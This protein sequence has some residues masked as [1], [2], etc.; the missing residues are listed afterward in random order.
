M[1]I[2]FFILLSYNNSF[3]QNK[4]LQSSD[5]VDFKNYFSQAG[6]FLLK[7]QSNDALQC[8]KKCL[9]LNS[10]S[11][12]TNFQIAKI[13]YYSG[14]YNAAELFAKN[15]VDLNSDNVFYIKFLADVYSKLGNYNLSILYS[16]KALDKAPTY[17][18]YN[19]L[20]ELYISTK[21]YNEAIEHLN[22]FENNFGFDVDIIIQKADLF[23]LSGDLNSA[24]KE[25]LRLIDFDS[26]NLS[27]YYLLFDFYSITNQLSKFQDVVNKMIQ[28]DSTNGLSYLAK[29]LMCRS[30]LQ[31]DCFYQNLVESF[32]SDDIKFSQKIFYIS[33]LIMDD[34]DLSI[35]QF[36]NLFS[37][38]DSQYHDS[39]SVHSNFADFYL[40][41]HNL[42][43]AIEQLKICLDIDKSDFKIW[44]K[45]FRIYT[46]NEDYSSL[47]DL[48]DLALSFYPEQLDVYLY[49]AVYNIYKNNL[50]DARD[51]LNQ[52]LDF[53]IE[54]SE[55]KFLYYFYN[56]ICLYKENNIDLAFENFDKFYSN[57]NN[58]YFLSSQYAFYLINA[59][60]N[61]DLAENIIKKCINFDNS[62]S[63][64]YFVYS[65]YF[66]RKNDLKSAVY[67][68]DKSINLDL[69]N[70]YYIFELAGDIFYKNN[71]FEKAKEYYNLAIS[72]GGNK[73]KISN[74]I[75][76][77]N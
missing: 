13:Y 67:F 14:D 47:Q 68:I 21:Q 8:Y 69:S 48:V 31:I 55:S 24:E 20:T 4:F 43:K 75:N 35:E 44:R 18:N 7:S 6:I 49:S 29:A 63:Y 37:V 66:L 74:K 25:I 30:R 61:F 77:C 33:N 57:I 41:Q 50:N 26:S 65:F 60:R 62:N 76:K 3:S 2:I 5:D 70:K 38:L 11:A 27:F 51:F 42:P 56:A 54:L 23:R 52:S 71:N 10:K 19:F 1:N 64:F 34:L 16:K 58:D 59:N 17:D 32:K 12:A 73:L 22:S 45:L 72:H 39:I 15:A 46:L 53:G 9:E 40:T 28:V 36:E